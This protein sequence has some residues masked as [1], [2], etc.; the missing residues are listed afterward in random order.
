[1]IE[2]ARNLLFVDYGKLE[3]PT[4]IHKGFY[5]LT[6]FG[7]EAVVIFFVISG[8]LVGGKAW[9]LWKQDRF[10]WKRYL[11]D[12]VSRLY[13]VLIVALIFGGL[14]DVA[15]LKW[16]NDFG[17][18]DHSTIENVAVVSERF[19]QRLS[20]QHFFGNLLMFQNI[21]IS[22][23]GSNGPLWSL[24]HEW[25]YYLLFPMALFVFKG[26]W[27]SRVVCLGGLVLLAWFLTPYILILFGVWLLGV[28]AW[29]C[30]GKSWL[31]SW[32]SFPIF[33]GCRSRFSLSRWSRCAWKSNSSRMRISFSWDLDSRV[34][35]IHFQHRNGDF[36]LNQ[37]L[38][39]WPIFPIHFTWFTFPWS[40]S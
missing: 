26:S 15:G 30:N 24:A 3:S 5:F 39:G 14:F 37:S 6:G 8:F 16:F 17:Y 11:V 32:M 31:P 21:Q 19:D 13:A 25:W 7:H 22:T 38:A 18:Y 33:A 34:C 12:R 40:Y 35:L 10:G 29:C 23:Y 27:P 1:M 2:H 9:S 36:R 20:I 4:V 28:V